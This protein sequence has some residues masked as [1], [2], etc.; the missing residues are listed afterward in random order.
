[1]ATQNNV[2]YANLVA[3]VPSTTPPSMFNGLAALTRALKKAGYK[4]KASS[5]GTTK[6]TTGLAVNDFWGGFVAGTISNVG[7]AAASITAAASGRATVTGLTGIVAADKGRFLRIQGSGSGNNGYMQIEEILSATSVRI[8]NRTV[9]LTTPDANNGALTWEIHDPMLN[10]LVA[11]AGA[12]WWCG[13]GVST[14]KLPITAAPAAGGSGFTF[15]RGENIT[16]ATTGF[17]GEILGF[18]FDTV[19]LTGHLVV[20]P[21]KIGTGPGAF[22][23]DTALVITGDTS[24]ATVTQVGAATEFR[25]QIVIWK[26]AN[27]TQGSI[28]YETIEIGVES[29]DLFSTL[30]TSAG[31]T[32][33]IAPGGG[34]TGN[35]FP[36]HA[37]VALG[38]SS[39][40][41]HL[42]WCGATAGA[43]SVFP[44]GR[45]QI[46]V[47]DAIWEVGYSADGTWT[48]FWPNLFNSQVS[49]CEALG[50][51]RLDDT[52][53]GDLDPYISWVTGVQPIYTSS[54]TSTGTSRTSSTQGI[55]DDLTNSPNGN[56]WDDSTIASLRGWI[57]RGFATGELFQNFEQAS[58]RVLQ[59]STVPA[60][61]VNPA[62]G[63]RVQA[64]AGIVYTK[65]PLW[66]ISVNVLRK[67][68][69][70]TVRW[71]SLTGANAIY[72]LY[73]NKRLIQ[74]SS[75]YP[76]F[77]IGPWDGATDPLI[78]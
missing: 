48:L 57:R 16:Q 43:T 59:T 74:V 30:A 36:T 67:C 49:G 66:I 41:G 75:T 34:G 69:K 27:A 32:A 45:M 39:S 5:D 78:N 44:M 25:R 50:Y 28:F 22:G 3:T 17:E 52:E 60:L 21:R 58:I 33:V 20:Q 14:L 46:P 24:G 8:D 40:G 10:T 65:E 64:Q 55:T 56:S 38:T 19:G 73:D 68:R 7:A 53:D 26:A 72:Q 4:Y 51:W 2:L 1:M 9:V 37:Y 35:A 42:E 15:L 62:E 31:C 12:A 29:A 11:H 76:A 13:E 18:I 71:V 54:R 63:E 6:D 47:A 70:G 23:T 61:S 77:V